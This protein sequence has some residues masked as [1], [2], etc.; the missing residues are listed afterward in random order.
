MIQG[1]DLASRVAHPDALKAAGIRFVCRYV[2]TAGNPKNLTASEA[3][4]LKAA[5]LAIVVVYETTATAALGG[6]IVGQL[7]ARKAV[8][9][10]EACGVRDRPI[11][12]AVDFDATPAQMPW[13]R[14]YIGGAADA[15]GHDR[16]GVYGSYSVVSSIMS[17]RI[18]K[19]GWQTYAWSDGK[20]YPD[21][22]LQQYQ[23]GVTLGGQTVDRD[24]A[25]TKDY[26]QWPKPRVLVLEVV[27]GNRLVKTVR[28]GG[29]RVHKYLGSV[30][31][32]R[33]LKR[34]GVSLRRRLKG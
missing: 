18:C 25:T 13:I 3:A 26:G 1:V 19:Y 17:Q 11:Y 2:S 5:G 12:F 10:A 28:Y 24:R 29:G 23:N 16:V 34:G 4:M 7:D 30:G 8:S 22:Q 6:R 14:A 27:Q 32:A 9:Q 20:W 33:L 21:A 15:I 31:F